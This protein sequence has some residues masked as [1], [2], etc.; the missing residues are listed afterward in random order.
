MTQQK[1]FT[2]VK[3]ILTNRA[4]IFFG[5]LL[6]LIL[7]GGYFSANYQNHLQYPNTA[8]ILKNYPAGKTVSVTGSVIQVYN[9]SFLL[10]DAYHRN[11]VYYKVFSTQ[12]VSVGDQVEVLG[13]LGN[14][15]QITASKIQSVSTFDYKFLLLRSFIALLIFLFFFRRYWHFDFKKIEFRRLK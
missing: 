1:P 8:V 5:L 14:S 9:N 3:K 6:V 15:Y 4:F 7:L 11:V 12:K 2:T 10:T 13:I